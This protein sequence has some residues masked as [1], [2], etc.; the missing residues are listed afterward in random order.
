MNRSGMRLDVLSDDVL[1]A[2][3][4]EVLSRS[5][6]VEAD[7]VAHIAE[8][9]ARR[10]YLREACPSMH[11]YATERLHLSDAEAYL[12]ITVARVSRRFPV[13]LAML[14]DG[15]LHLSAIAKLA[16]HLR[17][18]GAEVL[19]A[20]AA[21]RS[22]REIEL[23]L[24]ELAPKPDVPSLVRRLPTSSTP[25]NPC[26]LRPGG[27]MP[28]ETPGGPAECGSVTG[29]SSAPCPVDP[30]AT[31]TAPNR[32]AAVVPIAPTRYKVQFTASAELHEKIER[33]QALL[34]RQVPDG[35][36]AAIVDRAM[37]LLLRELERARFAA[38]AAPRKSA[39]DANTAPSSRHIPAPVKRA[40]WERDGGQCTFRNRQGQRCPA[41]ERLEFHHVIPFAQGGDHSQGN[42]R[43]A[44]ALCRARHKAHYADWRIMPRP[45]RS[46]R[47]VTWSY[48]A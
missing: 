7:L 31:P 14:A 42:I 30:P 32:S 12:R 34:R 9:D 36:L 6:R 21:R 40:V 25:A 35:D 8:V 23:L 15:R 4:R 18:D 13:A 16:P 28:P 45:L 47:G 44:C 19:L 26:Q 33:A 17:D 41:R 27:V 3:L 39:C 37:S 38:T 29:G 2:R 43:L 46:P 22:K 1:L 48:A 5:R 10:L 11:V 20:R 24:A